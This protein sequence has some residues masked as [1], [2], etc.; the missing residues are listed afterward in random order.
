MDYFDLSKQYTNG[1]VEA[2]KNQETKFLVVSFSTDW[3]YPTKHSKD[4]VI[5]LNAC[6]ANVAFSEIKTDK[7]H[8]A[9][10]VDEPE[11]LKTIKGFIDSTYL[12]CKNENRI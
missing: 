5:A 11:F 8:D 7:G 6:G 3:L 2:F 4:I 10:L 9:F 12:S 1:L